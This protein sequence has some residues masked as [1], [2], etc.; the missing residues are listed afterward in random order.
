LL[1]GEA[2]VIMRDV[3]F[4]RLI[5]DCRRELDEGG[6]TVAALVGDEM[7]CDW[8]YT[9][10]LHRNFGHPELLLVG[11]EAPVAGAVLELMGNRIAAGHRLDEGRALVMDGGL[12][13]R[14]RPVDALFRAQGDWFNLGREVMSHWGERWPLSLQLVWSDPGQEFPSHPGDP[15]WTTR[16]PLLFSA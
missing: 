15:R 16:Q 10:G 7:G 9:I 11:L 2:V 1:A 8:A 3:D 5:D 14:A 12:E 4:Q 6:F 13:F